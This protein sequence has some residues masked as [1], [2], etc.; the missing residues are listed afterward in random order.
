MDINRYITTNKLKECKNTKITKSTFDPESIWSTEI[1]GQIGSRER[2][3]IFAYIDLKVKVIHPN[4]YNMI[5]T[6][7]DS[8]SKLLD[9]KA[10][11]KIVDKILKEDPNGEDGVGFLVANID[12]I[13]LVKNCKKDKL[14]V[15]QY[16]EDNKAIIVI[17]KFPI[18]PAGY[19]DR[20]LKSFSGLQV[21]SDLNDLYRDVIYTCSKLSGIGEIDNLITDTIQSSVNHIMKWMQLKL[22]GKQ[23]VLRGSMLKKRMDY[24]SR[25]VASTDQ[26]IPIGHVGLPW[27]TA[28]SLYAPLFIYYAYQ[29]DPAIL[30]DI[31]AFTQKPNMDSNDLTKFLQEI[32]AL[33]QIVPDELR[34]KLE[35]IAS[36]IIKDGQV[37]VKRDPVLMR[38]NW[39]SAT[40]IITDGRV[41]KINALDIGPLDGDFDKQNIVEVKFRE[42]GEHPTRLCW[43]QYRAKLGN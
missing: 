30:E 6:C 31:K 1:F 14:S 33:P 37:L 29:K 34:H 10:K 27:H 15:A 36:E 2:K 42:F 24:S 7:A 32:T 26:N 5:K 11:Y 20:D 39:F 18:I 25:L 40:P 8:I 9:R 16:L 19:R 28:L 38:N 35:F 21:N 17:D 13:D 3:E 41:A 22:K 12:S 4:C 43:G 23:G